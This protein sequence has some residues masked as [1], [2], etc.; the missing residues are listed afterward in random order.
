ML[1]YTYTQLA[2]DIVAIMA[3]VISPQRY[4]YPNVPVVAH[5][6]ISRNVYVFVGTET[7]VQS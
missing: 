5:D 3:V 2:L 7:R 1:Y 4:N 6:R